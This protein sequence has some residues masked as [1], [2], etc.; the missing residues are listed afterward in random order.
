[1]V[2]WSVPSL[3]QHELERRERAYR[4]DRPALH[5]RDRIVI[6]VDDGLATDP[7]MRAA[8]HLVRRHAPSPIVLAIPTAAPETCGAF[9]DEVDGVICLMTPEPFHCVGLW[10]D[11]VHQ[12]TDAEV[13]DL[14]DRAAQ[15]VDA[16]QKKGAV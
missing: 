7:T 8:L 4:T 1:M 14:L 9:M 15:H 12:T 5:L 16:K 3:E 2:P 6:F 13:R 11:D 10:Y